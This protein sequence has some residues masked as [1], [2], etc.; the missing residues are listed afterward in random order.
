[1]TGGGIGRTQFYAGGGAHATP[2]SATTHVGGYWP[3]SVK[4]AGVASP[5]AVALMV[6]G[7]ALGG[8]V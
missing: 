2:A 8:S 7:P 6:T 5:V 3:V 4:T 1:M